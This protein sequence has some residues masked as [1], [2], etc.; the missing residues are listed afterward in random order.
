MSQRSPLYI[1]HIIFATCLFMLFTETTMAAEIIKCIDA[2]GAVTFRDVPCKAGEDA[3]R[4]PGSI[5]PVPENGQA[6]SQSEKHSAI[7]YPHAIIR[8]DKVPPDHGLSTDVATL[9]AARETLM[10]LDK[11]SKLM[12]QQTYASSD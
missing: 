7:R 6:M 2:K 3:V 5:N 10:S 8:I 11:V 1:I 9:K 12:H 4:L